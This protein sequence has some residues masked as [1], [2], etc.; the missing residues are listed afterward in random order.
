[1]YHLIFGVLLTIAIILSFV[2]GD[3]KFFNNNA[4]GYKL[5]MVMISTLLFGM[6]LLFTQG[7]TLGLK[8]IKVISVP[9][10]LTFLSIQVPQIRKFFSDIL[11][12]DIDQNEMSVRDFFRTR[13]GVIMSLSLFLMYFILNQMVFLPLF[14]S[15]GMMPDIKEGQILP[16]ARKDV[17]RVLFLIMSSII[18]PLWSSNKLSDWIASLAK[19]S[20]AKYVE[21]YRSAMRILAT[22]F[23]YLLSFTVTQS[24]TPVELGSA[25]VT[26]LTLFFTGSL[27]QMFRVMKIDLPP[28]VT[29]EIFTHDEA[30]LLFATVYGSLLLLAA[31]VVPKLPVFDSIRK[32]FTGNDFFQL[33]DLVKSVV[34]FWMVP[35]LTGSA[36]E[37]S[38][39]KTTASAAKV[40]STNGYALGYI[41]GYLL[42]LAGHVFTNKSLGVAKK[43]T[44]K[45]MD[46]I[47][48]SMKSMNK[49]PSMGYRSY[50]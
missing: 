1:M 5:Q 38:L 28:K 31:F 16:I 40:Q 39:K 12:I 46:S 44:D 9:S 20:N 41:V 49:M 17:P 6:P 2:F 22:L 30:A 18:L 13:F 48:N 37:R 11:G 10:M 21:S 35:S 24:I 45:A 4:V 8:I 26:A 19:N 14:S 47:N 43:Y 50:Y 27:F 34:L 29:S 15:Q 33:V 42:T 23:G 32:S 3:E 36:F 7:S 25:L